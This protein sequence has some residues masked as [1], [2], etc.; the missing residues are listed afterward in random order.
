MSSNTLFVPIDIHA[1]VVND[2][3]R[4]G[5]N[6]Q[7]WEMKYKNL[8]WYSSPMPAAFNSNAT[9]WN[10]DASAN[11]IYLHWTLPYALRTGAQQNATGVTDYP[12][13]PNRWLVVRYHGSR[14]R[15]QHKAGRPRN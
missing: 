9:D 10:T 5:Q 12:L 11:G 8:E 6:F 1:M 3:V 4:L 7:R 13:V 2:E 15:L 14:K